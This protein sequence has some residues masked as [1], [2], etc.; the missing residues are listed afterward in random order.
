LLLGAYIVTRI[1]KAWLQIF[2]GS[3][4]IAAVLIQEYVLPEKKRPLAIT[5]S[6]SAVGFLV[7]L[8]NATAANGIAPLIVW[9]RA[10]IV[11]PEQI[12]QNTAA[13]FVFVN[14]FSLSSIYFLR[15]STFSGKTPLLLASLIPVV[16]LGNYFGNR[17]I[18]KVSRKVYEKLVVRTVILIGLIS[19]SLGI[20]SKV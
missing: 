2:L 6:V 10:H 7:G 12:R 5:W 4:I 13:L 19:I 17:L 11:T 15:R 3:L 8:L 14:T 9:L 18:D 16:M 20:A 1:E